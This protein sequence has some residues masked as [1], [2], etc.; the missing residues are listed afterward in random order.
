[1]INDHIHRVAHPRRVD[2][3]G[4][5]SHVEHH[6]VEFRNPDTPNTCN[7]MLRYVQKALSRKISAKAIWA[8]HPRG[9]LATASTHQHHQ[10]KAQKIQQHIIA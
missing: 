2:H 6:C 3:G 8:A 10:V 1:M 5:V 4:K 7:Y 9:L